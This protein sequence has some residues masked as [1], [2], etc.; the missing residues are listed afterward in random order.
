[1]PSSGLPSKCHNPNASGSLSQYV[2]LASYHHCTSLFVVVGSSSFVLL[3]LNRLRFWLSRYK[4][5]KF[6]KI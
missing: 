2:T 6:V 3:E 4:I 5:L 1:V